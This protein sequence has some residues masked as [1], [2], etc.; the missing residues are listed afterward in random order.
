MSYTRRHHRRCVGSVRHLHGPVTA[1]QA[2]PRGP[3]LRHVRSPV[4][5]PVTAPIH[6]NAQEKN[7]ITLRTLSGQPV[8][9]LHAV[10]A[11]GSRQAL[12]AGRHVALDALNSLRG[13]SR[14][15]RNALLD[16]RD[17]T[18]RYLRDEPTKTATIVAAAGIVVL[19]LVVLL[20]QL[21]DRD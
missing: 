9:S 21:R 15:L 2:Q 7:V 11:K 13:N 5:Q 17:G 20:T 1:A 16:T 8:E 12:D 18:L 14:H 10:A 19:G 3:Y 4:S 6:A